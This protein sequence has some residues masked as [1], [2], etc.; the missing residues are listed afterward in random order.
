MSKSD[1]L[2]TSKKKKLLID[3]SSPTGT[4]AP[5]AYVLH[6]AIHHFDSGGADLK[7]KMSSVMISSN[8]NDRKHTRRGSHRQSLSIGHRL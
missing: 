7:G 6:H 4:T 3:S 5:L 1:T 2:L 8:I